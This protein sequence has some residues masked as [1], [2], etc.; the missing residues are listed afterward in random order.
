MLV[1]T[2]LTNP[3]KVYLPP[4]NIKLG[5][6][7]Y[8]FNARDQNSAKFMY[9]KNKFPRISDAEIKEGIFVGCQIRVNTGCE[10]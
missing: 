4:L 2:L 7:K 1:N 3:E 5:F 9:L 10:M 8:F 6:I